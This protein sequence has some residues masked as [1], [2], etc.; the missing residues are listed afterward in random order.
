MQV[1]NFSHTDVSTPADF[2]LSQN[3][4][5]PFNPETTISYRLEKSSRIQIA[6]YNV[7]GELIEIL[8]D[9]H[10]TPGHYSI[11]WHA[12]NIGSG[13]YLCRLQTNNFVQTRKLLLQR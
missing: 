8:V 13:I 11:R 4:P 7:L 10:Q 3:Y 5:N 9:E 6:I 2:E 12:Q 1:Q